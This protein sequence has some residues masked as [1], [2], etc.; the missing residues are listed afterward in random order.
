VE[1]ASLRS[2]VARAAGGSTT[3]V[4]V[5]G[6][7]G[8]GKTTLLEAFEP[9]ISAQGF[10]CL[11]GCAEELEAD[12]PFGP[13]IDALGVYR[14][15]AHVGESAERNA[16]RIEVAELLNHTVPDTVPMLLAAVPNVRH[17]IIANV[18]GLVEQHVLDEPV[19]ILIEDLHWADPSTTAA[20]NAIAKRVEGY[21]LLIVVTSRPPTAPV[22]REWHR[23]RDTANM[24]I[25]LSPLDDDG[26]KQFALNALGRTVGPNL[27]SLTEGTGGNPL[28][29]AELFRGLSPDDLVEVDGRIDV[30]TVYVPLTL[31]N[32]VERR[33]QR[34]TPNAIQLV[35]AA[36]VLGSAASVDL[37]AE[38]LGRPTPRL[39]PAIE[40]AINEG[41]LS[42]SGPA[43]TFRHDI[44][45]S[46]VEST[47]APMLRMT[48]HAEAAKVLMARRASSGVIAAHLEAAGGD[49]E[50][51]RR[52]W[53]H[54][55]ARE[56]IDR[57]PSVAHRLLERARAS[58][59]TGSPDWISL[60]VESLEAST[61]A[62]M[63]S[64]AVQLG[65][66]LLTQPLSD[67]VRALTRWWFGGSLFLA[68]RSEE[69][70]EQFELAAQ[71]FGS[72]G[73]RSL[74][75]AYAAMARLGAFS[76]DASAAVQRATA[77]ANASGDPRALSLSLSL[78]SR[79]AGNELRFSDGIPFARRAMEVAAADPSHTAQRYQPSF[80]LALVLFDVGHLKESLLAI[81]HGQEQA[82]AHGASW[83]DAM[84][85]QLR[86]MVLYHQGRL[87][88]ADADAAAGLAASEETGSYV[89]VLWSYGIM[90]LIALHRGRNQEAQVWIEHGERV[91]ASGQAQMGLDLIVAARGQLY[92]AEGNVRAAAEHFRGAW[93]VFELTRVTVSLERIALDF[94]CA[95][96]VLG[97]RGEAKA[98]FE[99]IVHWTERD[100][101]SIRIGHLVKTAE[102]TL[103]G[104]MD[105]IAVLSDQLAD[106]GWVQDGEHHRRMCAIALGIAG[107]PNL[108][109]HQHLPSTSQPAL[110]AAESWRK[111]S[112]AEQ[113]VCR[114]IGQ[115]LSNKAIAADLFLSVRTVET[116][117]SRIL[118]KLDV[119][120]R[121]QLGL[122]VRSKV[123]S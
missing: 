23:L 92:I 61:N 67:E 35:R 72:D 80:F 64:E 76:P 40:E 99:Q 37:L 58:V 87:D 121:L 93:S 83:A 59:P 12:R 109:G 63:V 55:A 100:P 60:S 101:T 15:A 3:L 69:A 79:R 113:R 30:P 73:D 6:E 97:R 56:A 102:A 27:A 89:S 103:S 45:R 5:T 34:L 78:E 43:V 8:M 117:V 7:A 112:Q 46:A 66:E 108:D 26:R 75:L 22:D 118:K 98:I 38:V 42:D 95:L 68:Q 106:A 96:I 14:S 81:R 116:H 74:L 53:L 105:A 41:L 48:L 84:Y 44:L 24:V 123:D 120:S 39:L 86:A 19:A 82:E 17:R 50:D 115:G 71:E 31:I 4:V 90:A 65:R 52:T 54:Q 13:I 1:V 110:S 57:S 111:L 21:Q 29:L 49:D 47:M 62:G 77:S 36:S 28:F 122:L 9:T 104:D 91:F 20:L 85:L 25:S 119:P 32:G 33:L 2:A 16:L 88:D 107:P 114:A 18:C 51:T 70:A 94:I 11:R 10:R